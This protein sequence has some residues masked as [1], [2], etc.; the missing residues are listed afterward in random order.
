MSM[1]TKNPA[2]L[3]ALENLAQVVDRARLVD[4]EPELRQLQRDV[5]LDARLR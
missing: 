4:V 2:G 1:R 5:A 3:G